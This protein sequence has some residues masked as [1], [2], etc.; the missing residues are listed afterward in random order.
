MT[1]IRSSGLILLLKKWSETKMQNFEN[2]EELVARMFEKLDG[3]EPVSVVADK[4]LAISIMRE[5]LEYTNIVLKY[6]NINDW[7][8]DKEYLVS[9]YDDTD[10]WY[11]SIEQIYNYEK[12]KYL[13][14]VGYVLFH[15]DVNSKALV[16]MQNNENIEL[17][18]YNWFVI[19]EDDETDDEDETENDIHIPIVNGK[20]VSVDEYN[21]FVSKFAPDRVQKDDRK[22]VTDTTTS[23]EVFKV[24]GQCVNKEIYE[25][26]FAKFEDR[27]LDNVRDM[28]LRYASFMDDWNEL[29]KLFY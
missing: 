28:L 14:T 18:G 19:R 22:S 29:L 12:E 11:V 13:G 7:D 2:V 20:R 25:K 5:L 3:D 27:Y 6:A 23:K 9:L 16:D 4:D 8:Y 10:Y 26:E 15:E 24:N 21:A 17:S 1:R